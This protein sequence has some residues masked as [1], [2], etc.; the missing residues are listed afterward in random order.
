MLTAKENMR[1]VFVAANRIGLSTSSK[2]S[3]FCSTPT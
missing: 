1:E 3:H 2:P